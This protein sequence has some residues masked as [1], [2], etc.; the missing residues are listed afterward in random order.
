[1]TTAPSTTDQVLDELEFLASA[2]H[3]LITEYLTVGYALSVDLPDASGVAAGLAQSQMFRLNNVCQALVAAGRGPTLNRAASIAVGSADIPFSPAGPDGY[4]DLLDRESMIARAVDDRYRGLAPSVGSDLAK[5]VGESG[6]THLDALQ[7]LRD[8]I[9]DPAPAGLLRTVRFEP[10]SD[11]ESTLL[12]A[13]DSAYR[14]VVTALR[15]MYGEEFGD[16]RQIANTAML[17]LDG[18]NRVLAQSGLLPSFNP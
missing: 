6:P 5:L 14:V 15:A 12:G 16:Y 13:S 11:T 8:A 18:I 4:A 1:M 7:P 3:A 17:A 10:G 2:E 9:G